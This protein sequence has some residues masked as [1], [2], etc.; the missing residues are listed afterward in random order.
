MSKWKRRRDRARHLEAGRARHVLAVGRKAARQL[1]RFVEWDPGYDYVALERIAI[2]YGG[3]VEDGK[4]VPILVP[5]RHYPDIREFDRACLATGISVFVRYKEAYG[6]D[7][8][9]TLI[10][11]SRRADADPDPD[12]GGAI[13][14]LPP[15]GRLP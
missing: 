9:G 11:I 14:A 3:I 1:R 15:P 4:D 7:P 6:P 12:P 5:W 8:S 13:G 2:H 10:R